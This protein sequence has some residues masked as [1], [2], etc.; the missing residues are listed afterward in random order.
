MSKSD[1]KSGKNL[2]TST[3]V[4]L[5]KLLEDYQK[6]LETYQMYLKNLC[7]GV[8]K[9]RDYRNYDNAKKI[10]EDFD[11]DKAD[12]EDIMVMEYEIDFMKNEIDNLG[13]AEERSDWKWRQ[14]SGI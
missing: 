13:Y 5:Q 4:K 10:L 9:K 7:Y 2:K 11:P 14:R 8:V 1:N 6:T 3:D 12:D